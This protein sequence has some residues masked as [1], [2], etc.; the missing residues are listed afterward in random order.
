MDVGKPFGQGGGGAGQDRGSEVPLWWIMPLLRCRQ[1]C[2]GMYGL[3]AASFPQHKFCRGKDKGVG[4]FAER[5]STR[6]ALVVL[7]SR[8]SYP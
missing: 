4:E 3:P 7:T 5:K 8:I 2:W 6:Q 1:H